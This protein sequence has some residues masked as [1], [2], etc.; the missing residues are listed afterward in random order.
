[1]NAVKRG[2]VYLIGA[3]P[4]DPELLTLKAARILKTA[5]VVLYDRLVEDSL[6]AFA[7]ENSLKICVGKDH[8]ENPNLKQVDI[9]EQMLDFAERGKIVARLKSGDPFV[10]GRGGEEVDFLVEHGIEVVVIPGL[11]S[12]ISLPELV[13][14]PVTHRDYSSSITI[15][16]GH[17]KSGEDTD[18][19]T[20]AKLDGTIIV[21]MGMDAIGKITASLMTAG[22][23]RDMPVC[24][25]QNGSRKTERTVLGTLENI[26]QAALE[27]GF[28]SPALIIIGRVASKLI[29]PNASHGKSMVRSHIPV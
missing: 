25:I 13:G 23:S 3:G 26:S 9:N 27:G 28:S 22:M 18:W 20:L 6:L 16:S 19:K 10:F 17:R 8:G 11:T 14:I 7:S 21:L 2:M 1:M 24:I 5:D 4:G 12:A 15:V 29:N